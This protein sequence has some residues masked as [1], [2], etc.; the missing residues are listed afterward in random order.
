MARP[1]AAMP[2]Y[3]DASLAEREAGAAQRAQRA[4]RDAANRT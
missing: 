4:R 3:G 2:V 1:N